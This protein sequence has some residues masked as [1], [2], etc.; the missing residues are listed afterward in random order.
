MVKLVDW[1]MRPGNGE[2]INSLYTSAFLLSLF[3]LLFYFYCPF[4]LP[5]ISL[6]FLVHCT[7]FLL[8]LSSSF[9]PSAIIKFM[10]KIYNKIF[11]K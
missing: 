7:F 5:F 11:D 2:K 8:S 9:L 4:P 1:L 10:L 3:S 6:L